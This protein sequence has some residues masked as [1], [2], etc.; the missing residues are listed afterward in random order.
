ME[1][2]RNARAPRLAPIAPRPPLWRSSSP[3]RRVAIAAAVLTTAVVLS[4]WGAWK[5]ERVPLPEVGAAR[6]AGTGL[7]PAASPGNAPAVSIAAQAARPDASAKVPG[8]AMAKP[9]AASRTPAAAVPPATTSPANDRTRSEPPAALARDGRTDL[10]VFGREYRGEVPFIG[11]AVPL[12]EGVWRVVSAI[13]GNDLPN[14]RRLAVLARIES[15]RVT[16]LLVLLGQV[17]GTGAQAG[18]P[19]SRRCDERA[20]FLLEVRA[21]VEFGRQSCLIVNHVE[22]RLMRERAD[23]P[24]L[25][26]ALAEIDNLGAKLPELF[27]TIAYR[28]AN[29]RRALE[30]AL[31]VDPARDG[32]VTSETVWSR[33]EWH[34]DAIDG[35]PVKRAY[36]DR[37]AA[38]GREFWPQVERAADAMNPSR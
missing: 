24:W 20:A 36:A 12:Q 25:K 22:T 14:S 5:R 10:P 35:H 30:L 21:N 33:S 26:S 11:A 29:D 17:G 32:H 28:D 3:F 18:Y 23:P 31:L 2:Q 6:Y 7:E 19:K 38:L 4:T 15:S 1:A 37:L 13:R 8:P 27:F 9:A 16:G 34:R